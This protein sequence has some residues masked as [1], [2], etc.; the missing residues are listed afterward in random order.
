MIAAKGLEGDII[1]D[2]AIDLGAMI[3]IKRHGRIDGGEGKGI[4][5]SDFFQGLPKTQVHE[6]EI[7]YSD[8]C[9]GKARKVF[10]S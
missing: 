5:P 4:L 3:V 10:P 7:G 1:F 6:Y 2:G 8:P 9:T